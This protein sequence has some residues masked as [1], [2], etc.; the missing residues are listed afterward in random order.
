MPNV[1]SNVLCICPFFIK[2]SGKSI[3]C[4]GILPNT[5]MITDFNTRND[6]SLF[7][8]CCCFS[9]DYRKKCR[10]FKS[11]SEKYD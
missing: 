1:G 7:Q 10:L 8:K 5:N 4:E 6:K 3:V 9:F 11:I 2:D